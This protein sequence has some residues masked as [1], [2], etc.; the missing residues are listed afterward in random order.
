MDL[1]ENY[2]FVWN[3]EYIIIVFLYVYNIIYIE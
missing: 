2:G 3:R 1:Y